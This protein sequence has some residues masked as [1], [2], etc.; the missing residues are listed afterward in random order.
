MTL[1]VL[2][3]VQRYGTPPEIETAT[4]LQALTGS[5]VREEYIAST[6]QGLAA[7]TPRQFRAYRRFVARNNEVLRHWVSSNA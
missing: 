4:S 7:D 1:S 6:K 2:V 5:G 3:A